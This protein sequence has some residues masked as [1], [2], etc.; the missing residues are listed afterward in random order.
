MSLLE[1]MEQTSIRT[2]IGG[3]ELLV[4]IKGRYDIKKGEIAQIV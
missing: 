2:L 1:I 4:L 3:L